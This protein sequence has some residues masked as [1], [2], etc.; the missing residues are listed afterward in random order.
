MRFAVLTGSCA[1]FF[2]NA[3]VVNAEALP[4]ND[5]VEEVVVTGSYV[6]RDPLRNGSSVVTL[7]RDDLSS[8]G[9]SNVADVINFLPFNSGSEF[10]ADVFTQNLSSGTSNFNLRGLGLNSTLLLLNGRRQTVSGGVA[11]DGSTFVDL[12]ALVPLNTVERIEILKDG[13]AALYGTDA[14]AGVVNVITRQDVEGLEVEADFS[15]TTRSSQQDLT[16][17]GLYGLQTERFTGLASVGYLRRSWLPSPE[18]AYTQ[19]KG[20]SSFGQPGAFILLEPSPIFPDLPFGL[21]DPQSVIDPDCE[22]GGG[23][24]NERVPGTGLGT[25]T[26]DFAPYYHLI[27]RERRWL[28]F[29][30]G[31]LDL[32]EIEFFA[33]AGYA[34]TG[35]VRG[36]SPS[37]PILNLVAV[38]ADN[39][40]NVFQTPALFLGRPLGADAPQ[41]L[42]THDSE[43]WRA[44][45]GLRGRLREDWEWSLSTSYSANRHV[46]KINNALVDQFD[47]ALNGRGGPDGNQYFNPFGS[48]SLSQ[49]G[50]S[51]YNDPAVI[52]GFL[53]AATYD[54][55]TSLFAV[56]GLVSGSLTELNDGPVRFALGGQVRREDIRGDLDDQFNAENYLFLV[57][58]P[59][60]S[61]ERTVIAGFGEINIPLTEA[62]DVQLAL[63]HETYE[64][65]LKSTDPKVSL[66]WRP[67]EWLSGKA[68]FGTAFR[69][70]SV[71]QNFSSQTV[72]QNINDP[73]TN[74][75]VFRGVRT[76]GTPDLKPETADVL[77]VG[78]TL[79]PQNGLSF[80]LDYWRFDYTDIIV[81][82][83]AQ[84]LVDADPFNPRIVREAG[85]I[86][87]VDTNYLNAPSVLTDGVDVSVA[88]TFSGARADQWALSADV[89]YINQYTIQ[90]T[91]GRPERDVAGSRNF[92]T[93]ARSLPRWRSTLGATWTR[94][95]LSLST[96][97]RTISGYADDQNGVPIDGLATFDAQAQYVLPQFGFSE[98]APAVFTLGVVN[99]FDKDPPNV[100]TN[101]GFDSKVHDPRGR[102][103][104][105]RI[106]A[107]F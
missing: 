102:V 81:K 19:G 93:F 97:L 38:P 18:R 65:G 56:D 20:F 76:I 82:E 39:P 1:A 79:T 35:V 49:P 8:F 28:S 25:C 45:G 57:G 58:G 74:S 44:V 55:Q 94:S 13:A 40:G 78:L 99:L 67:T 21:T 61:G 101:V 66:S 31:T 72:L 34:D 30:S 17:Q 33:E 84:A 62:V 60:F 71:F 105:A 89:T 43:T 48:A 5:G 63:R 95:E 69:A 91:P 12:N 86:L 7:S 11:D 106:K 96:Y 100:E 36:T 51:T 88:Y 24:P 64:G 52:A 22:A 54:Y 26:F 107:A 6:K 85:Q 29:A 59:D 41:N 90:Q 14:V 47:A 83:N 27:P 23:V 70:P 50:E 98:A 68:S 87:R 3:L 92:S 15:T 32:G 9:L 37:F 42:V 16:L 4:T 46:V 103:I 75:L 77:N 10:N 73:V 53:S 2:L 104:Y 80:G